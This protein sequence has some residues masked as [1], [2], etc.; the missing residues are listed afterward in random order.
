MTTSARPRG[1]TG[2]VALGGALGAV[3]GWLMMGAVRRALTP[4]APVG[5]TGPAG[6]VLHALVSL[7]PLIAV[8]VTG[9]F[10]LGLLRARAARPGAADRP[11][12]VAGL[13]TGLLGSFTTVS[14][15]AALVLGPLPWGSALGALLVLAVLSTVAAALGLRAGSEARAA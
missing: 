12:L 3:S 2:A 15:A 10:L 11:R 8:N 7:L 6:E 9:S 1:V 4:W 13:G 14:T 5:T